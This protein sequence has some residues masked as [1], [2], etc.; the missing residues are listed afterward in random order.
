MCSKTIALILSFFCLFS[1]AFNQ[2]RMN[3]LLQKNKTEVSGPNCFNSVL[4]SLG[5]VD[6]VRYTSDAEF[7]S[8]VNAFCKPIPVGESLKE[9]DVGLVVG[10]DHELLHGFIYLDSKRIFSKSGFYSFFHYEVTS[11]N[12]LEMFGAVGSCSG[13]PNPILNYRCTERTKALELENQIAQLELRFQKYAF[14]KRIDF[15]PNPDELKYLRSLEL[16]LKNLKLQFEK[17]NFQ[18]PKL[19]KFLRSTFESL[20]FNVGRWMLPDDD[21]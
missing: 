9:G 1:H 7:A 15:Y 8:A 14:G 11:V 5:I 13:C 17:S 19:E 12:N 16:E 21:D 10:S 18:N 4:Y 2:T 6:G 3:E 20:E